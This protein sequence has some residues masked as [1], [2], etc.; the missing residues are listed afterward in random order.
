MVTAH[1]EQVDMASNAVQSETELED[2]LMNDKVPGK[3][4]A[5]AS[6]VLG[7]IAVA[8]WFFGTFTFVLPL[9]SMILGIVGLILAGRAKKAGY[10]DGIRTAG[11][12]LSLLGLIVGAIVFISC[13]ACFG[14]VGTYVAE[15]PD[16]VAEIENSVSTVS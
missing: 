11:F 8:F 9:L 3:N 15:N 16:V 12:V 10:T 13:I 5:I 2:I 1:N 4:A 6:L 7:I 14:A